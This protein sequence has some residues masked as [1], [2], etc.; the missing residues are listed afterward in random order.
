MIT[1]KDVYDY[2]M[3]E[4]VPA[5][6]AAIVLDD[7]FPEDVLNEIRSAMTHVAR[8]HFSEDDTY[9]QEQLK[10][11]L[12][13]LRR[14]CLDCLKIAILVQSEK[15]EQ[16]IKGLSETLRLPDH[17]YRRFENIKNKRIQVMKDESVDSNQKIVNDY[18]NILNEIDLTYEELSNEFGGESAANANRYKWKKR[19]EGFIVG[20]LASAVVSIILNLL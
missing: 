11:A 4:V 8:S 3:N 6:G 14:V 19:L 15:V 10:A 16:I 5:L 17:Y 9:K 13:H 2:Y 1:E 20:I 7:K 12:N 18:K